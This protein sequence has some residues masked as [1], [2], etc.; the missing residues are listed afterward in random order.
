MCCMQIGPSLLSAVGNALGR[1]LAATPLTVIEDKGVKR[2]PK[3]N[4]STQA[5]DSGDNLAGDFEEADVREEAWKYRKKP[6]NKA[7]TL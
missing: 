5:L 4:T 2:P 7:R 3:H 1:S 6:K